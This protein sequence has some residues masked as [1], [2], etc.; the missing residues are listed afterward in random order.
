MKILPFL[1]FYLLIDFILKNLKIEKLD[2]SHKTGKLEW[3][4]FHKENYVSRT[5]TLPGS[6]LKY[7][8]IIVHNPTG[9]PSR[10]QLLELFRKFIRVD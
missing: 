6:V 10:W 2:N 5:F 9:C 7:E 8:F 4:Y 3:K 1:K